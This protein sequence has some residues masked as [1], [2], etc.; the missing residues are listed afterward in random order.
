VS[1]VEIRY[2][3]PPA[4]LITFRQQ[5]VHRAADC[6]V[7]CMEHAE[8]TAPVR[9]RG[10][11]VLE[12]GAPVVWFTFPNAWY[13]VGL[14][15]TSAGLVTGWY[16]NILTPVQFLS[17]TVWATTDLFLDVWLDGERAELLDVD[18]LA[19]AR[20][21]GAVRPETALRARAEADRIL[22]LCRAGSWPPLL[23]RDWS[24]DRVRAVLRE[25]GGTPPADPV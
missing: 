15:H 7:T 16:T 14:F 3:R 6:I 23:C 1:V 4:R 24:L 20:N 18:E 12:R 22:A 11:I 21:A 5:L 19:A 13:D 2:T 25:R 9:V 8:L 17:P 10:T